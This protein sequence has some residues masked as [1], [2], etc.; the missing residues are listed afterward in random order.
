M[1]ISDSSYGLN[2]VG[3]FA[4]ILVQ[5]HNPALFEKTIAFL[6]I[7]KITEI[8]RNCSKDLYPQTF[9]VLR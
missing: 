1:M 8:L 5:I 6:K 4:C 9:L 7:E 2:L 3:S